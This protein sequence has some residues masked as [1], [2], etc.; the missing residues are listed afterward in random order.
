MFVSPAA[1][2]TLA[3]HDALSDHHRHDQAADRGLLGTTLHGHGHADGTP[4]HEH[5]LLGSS[6]TAPAGAA[7]PV[8]LTGDAASPGLPPPRR[9]RG[10]MA[11]A[12]RSVD[13][14]G[15]VTVLRI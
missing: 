4:A 15:R 13:P 2:A 14:P 10:N 7:K 6:V 9:V 5:P 8:A 3:L 11:S 12:R 1:S